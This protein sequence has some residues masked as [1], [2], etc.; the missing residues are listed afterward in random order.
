MLVG[1]YIA[2]TWSY[3]LFTFFT[4]NNR[5]GYKIAGRGWRWRGGDP[6]YSAETCRRHHH[7]WGFL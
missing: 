3:F 6:A 4:V 7:H 2:L 5:E 1:S